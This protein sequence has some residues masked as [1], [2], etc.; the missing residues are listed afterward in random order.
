MFMPTVADNSKR[1]TAGT[2]AGSMRAGAAGVTGQSGSFRVRSV[3]AWKRP[4]EEVD[5]PLD[6]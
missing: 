1:M 5:L 2:R 3:K 6:R 4:D